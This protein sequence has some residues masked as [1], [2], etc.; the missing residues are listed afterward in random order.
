MLSPAAAQL[1][2][3]ESAEV[4]SRDRDAELLLASL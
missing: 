3:R 2:T 1:I 4:S